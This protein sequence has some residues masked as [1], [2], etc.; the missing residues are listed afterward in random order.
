MEFCTLVQAKDLEKELLALGKTK[1]ALKE[2]GQTE[3][4][5]Q[6]RRHFRP[7]NDLLEPVPLKVFTRISYE[8]VYVLVYTKCIL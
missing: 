8:Y 1:T 4:V 7:G 3:A 6:V 5:L 2:D